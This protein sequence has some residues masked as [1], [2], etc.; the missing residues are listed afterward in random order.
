VAAILYCGT[1]LMAP[2]FKVGDRVRLKPGHRHGGFLPGDTATVVVVLPPSTTEGPPLY[3]V[4]MNRT[5]GGLYATF[6][7][8]ESEPA[9]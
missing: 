7:A 1:L 6:Y 5:S 4:R 9:P 8:D 3:H 2:V